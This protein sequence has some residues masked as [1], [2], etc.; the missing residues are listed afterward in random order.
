[1]RNLNCVNVKC[2]FVVR[3]CFLPTLLNCRLCSTNLNKSES[4][5][6]QTVNSHTQKK[7][8]KEKNVCFYIFISFSSQSAGMVDYHR[9]TRRCVVI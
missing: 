7:K 1:M 3:L 8:T 2:C 4:I 6:Y 5:V 9:M